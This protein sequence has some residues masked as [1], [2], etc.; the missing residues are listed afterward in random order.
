MPFENLDHLAKSG[1]L[2]DSSKKLY[3][4]YLNKLA[5]AGYDTIK[6]LSSPK[7]QTEVLKLV[8][9]LKPRYHKSA[10]TAIF[11]ALSESENKC[12]KKYYD[13]FQE[14]KLG[15]EKLQTY[16]ASLEEE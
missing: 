14:L 15:D 3:K 1:I 5:V 7:S 9:S 4:S 10:L 13:Y 2:A 6:S 12:K 11:Y 16:K 8:K